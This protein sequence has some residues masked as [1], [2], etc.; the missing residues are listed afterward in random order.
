MS[1]NQSQQDGGS[2]LQASACR[3]ERPQDTEA[4]GTTC[5]R[6]LGLKLIDLQGRGAVFVEMCRQDV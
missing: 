4:G 6:I 3:Q 2:C 5:R 1:Q